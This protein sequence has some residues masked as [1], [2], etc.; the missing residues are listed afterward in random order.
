MTIALS[1]EPTGNIPKQSGQ[2]GTIFI[3]GN[4]VNMGAVLVKNADRMITS[5]NPLK[6]GIELLFADGCKGIIPFAD[7]PEIGGL[8]NLAGIE[9][10]NPYEVI[11]HNS[12][13]G[14]VELPWDFARHYCDASYKPR[15]EAIATAGRQSI[16]SRIRQLRNAAKMSQKELATAARIGRVTLVRIENGGQSPRYETLVALAG[17]LG[18]PVADLS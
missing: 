7:I 15:V 17:G 2:P 8:S 11:L 18:L 13:G 9:L 6:E 5:A 4:G 14:T 1:S 3:K 16:G 10:A 12:N